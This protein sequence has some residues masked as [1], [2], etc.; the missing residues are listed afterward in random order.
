AE[1]RRRVERLAPAGAA[2]IRRELAGPLAVNVV[3]RALQLID[4]LAD[5]V[6][7]WYDEIV[8]AVDRVSVGGEIGPAARDAVDDL[9][10]SVTRTIDRGAGVLAA[11]ADAL[12]VR[13]GASNAPAMM[14]GGLH[15]P[16]R[17]TTTP[18][19]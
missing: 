5:T 16:H 7:G 8:A 10:R 3:V 6:R 17:L 12:A 14:F 1:A 4:A 19:S 9:G 15:A 2:E 13:E 11:A 18:Y